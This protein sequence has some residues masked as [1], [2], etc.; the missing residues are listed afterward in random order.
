MRSGE[1]QNRYTTSGTLLPNEEVAIMPEVSGRIVSI[2]FAEGSLV[3]RGQTLVRLYDGDILASIKKLQAQRAL[4]RTIQSRQEELV[5]IGGI[6]RQDL[7]VTRTNIQAI[8]ADISIQQAE[9]RKTIVVAPFDGQAGLRGVSVGAVVTPSSVIAQLQQV[10]PLKLDFTL[11]ARYGSQLRMGM[12]VLFVVSGSLDTLK[13]KVRAVDPGADIQTR[14]VRARAV[15]PNSDR[16]LSP[17]QFARVFVP[18][19]AAESAI[20]IP[21]QAVVPT[22]REKKVARV[23]GG[24]VEMTTVTLGAR[25]ES[26]VEIT[27]GLEAGDTILLTGLMQAKSGAP[28][29]VVKVRQ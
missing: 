24:K 23:K 8:D 16:G 7:D 13:A 11:P 19:A 29:Q 25:T 18:L 14:T 5:R 4:Q 17:G 21:S 20:L 15:V 9:L 2:S 28:V 6:A 1:F 10:N 3:R 27:A 12:E 22:T 26:A